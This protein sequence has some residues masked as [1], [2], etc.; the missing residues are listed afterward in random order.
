MKIRTLLLVFSMIFS[1]FIFSQTKEDA[2][3]IT[4]NYDLEKIKALETSLRIKEA[5]EK[6]AAYKAA[7]INGWPITI[8]TEDGAFQELMKLTPDGFPV[9]YS[10]HNINAARS[11]RTNYLNTGGGLGLTLDGQNMVARVWDGGTVR[12]T[13]RGFETGRLT[14]VDDP[15][16]TTYDTH[17]THV[18]GTIIANRWSAGSNSIKGMAFQATARTFNWTDDESEALSEVALGMLVSN[19]SYGV[20]VTGT[21]GTLPSWYIGSYV[22]DSRAWDEI[23][24]LSPYYLPIYSAGNDGTNN[25]NANPIAAGYDKL[26]GNK[27]AKNV[28]TVANAQDAVINA[29]GSLS[30][31]LINS[32]SSQGPSDD[33]RIKPDIAGNG[34]SVNSL[35]DTSDTATTNMSGTSMAAPNVTGTLLLLQQHYKNLTNSFMRAATLKGLACHTADDAGAV[36][37]D[38]VF[39][40]GLLN[41]KKAA[42]TISN[43]GLSSWVSEEKLNQG[44]TFTM[45]V[46]SNGGVNNPLIASIT[47]TDVPGEANNGQRLTPNDP[48]KSLVNDLDI[49]ITKDGTTYYPWRLD[50]NA[51]TS[52]ALRNGDNDVDNVEVIKIDAPAAGNYVITI[53]HKGNL[54]SGSQNYSLVVTGIASNFALVPTS[55]NAELCS[56]QT[57]TYTFSY[58]QTGGATTNFSTVGI[59]AGANATIS[60]TSLNTNGTVTLTVSNLPAVIPGEYNVGIVGNNGIESE[61]RTKVLKIYSSTFQPVVITSPT[62]GFNGAATTVNLRWQANSNVENQLVQLSTSPTFSTFVVNQSTPN[63]NYIVSGLNQDTMYYWRIVPSN[64]CGAENEN[65]AVVNSFRTGILSC[66]NTFS[67]TDFSDAVLAD[68]ANSSASVPV[69]VTGGLTIGEMR[70]SFDMTH[71]YVQDMTITLQGPASIGSPVVILLQQPCGDNDDISCRFVDSGTTPACT[72]VPAISGDIAPVDPFTNLNGLIADGTWT[73][74]VDDPFNGDGGTISNFTIEICAVTASLSSNDNVFNSL[75]VF[76]NPAKGTVNIDLAGAVT[77]DT[78]YELFDVQGRKVVTKVS[79]NN[80]E[81]LNVENLS[82]GIYMLSIQNGSTKTTKKVVINN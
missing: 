27:V 31:V 66:G 40:W 22:D 19:H 8:K 5:A 2:E 37:P 41:A 15:S 47:W 16:G 24:Y 35:S 12:R 1:G 32:S 79:S 60:P 42:E 6:D 13:H 78:T 34:T 67:A 49:R 54:V 17:P 11:T 52:P 26:V 45:S 43:N 25:N 76:P 55:E 46:S 72:G 36:G 82:D 10:T 4:K 58:N 18:T 63:T 65:S 33:R 7:K 23:A 61:T 48:F 80:F 53:T 3:K 14:T 51:P 69:T 29:D 62:N 44:Q 59:P 21:G 39:G 57:A 28:L 70:V 56:N 81:T 75:S 71:T 9:Y 38:P 73:L 64:R 68:V 50:V 20:P 74:L 30:S 77:G